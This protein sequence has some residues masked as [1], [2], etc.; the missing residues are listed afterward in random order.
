MW[1][2]DLLV[3]C[4]R[5]EP[6]IV[7]QRCDVPQNI[8]RSDSSALD[9]SRSGHSG[10]PVLNKDGEVIGWAV[11]SHEDLG[12]NG[13]LRPIEK[14]EVPLQVVI[15][16]LNRPMDADV[17][18]RLHGQLPAQQRLRLGDEDF[19]RC[20]ATQQAAEAA[21][22]R[23]M[24][25]K[26]DAR[27]AQAG[28]QAAQ[29]GA[30]AAQASAAAVPQQAYAAGQLG[31]LHSVIQAG[32]AAEAQLAGG[33]LVGVLPNVQLLLA[34]SQAQLGRIPLGHQAMQGMPGMQPL[35]LHDPS[36]RTQPKAPKKVVVETS[37]DF[38]AIKEP[39]QQ[40]EFRKLLAEELRLRLPPDEVKLM[41]NGDVDIKRHQAII[42]IRGWDMSPA[43]RRGFKSF[44]TE[45]L[46]LDKSD[47]NLVPVEGSVHLYIQA[48]AWAA[49]LLTQLLL[50]NDTRICSIL[51]CCDLG[52]PVALRISGDEVSSAATKVAPA[53]NPGFKKSGAKRPAAGMI[54]APS[55]LQRVPLRTDAAQRSDMLGCIHCGFAVGG[56]VQ[57]ALD[58]SSMNDTFLPTSAASRGPTVGEPMGMSMAL[59][60][61]SNLR[62]SQSGA[63]FVVEEGLP[64]LPAIERNVR[65]G[66]CATVG[67][68]IDELEMVWL[69]VLMGEADATLKECATE[70]RDS[71]RSI[72]KDW[73][74]ESR[75]CRP[76]ALSEK[77]SL[78][79]LA[80]TVSESL[81]SGDG[82]GDKQGALIFPSDM[83]SK[84]DQ[85]RGTQELTWSNEAELNKLL[86][87]NA[88][89]IAFLVDLRIDHGARPVNANTPS[90]HASVY[91][92]R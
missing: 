86:D 52:L 47:I 45:F 36:G 71:T 30:Q 41:E 6:E 65:A 80:R 72:F 7:A 88:L 19:H 81:R 92:R 31:H 68:L 63:A 14:L 89:H 33:W 66:R 51:S 50:L 24:A 61:I 56:C 34:G 15:T 87:E 69:P 44:V 70:L 20:L 53:A 67:Q 84:I 13:Q 62:S 90:V 43:E 26:T 42:Q 59:D 16:A 75:I 79:V 25:A 32:R 82:L 3:R 48:P 22:A 91:V 29:A 18:D 12:P 54:A 27:A 78:V 57:C 74:R 46:E 21:A 39:E 55:K 49:A 73:P 2:H 23:A 11:K 40:E 9:S 38:S 37:G 77:E 58:V 1:N 35:V 5:L 60:I 10:S 28:A 64:N 8:H 83:V 17:R 4:A 76:P 85:L